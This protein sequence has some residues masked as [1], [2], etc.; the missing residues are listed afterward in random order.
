MSVHTD[1]PLPLF[2]TWERL[3]SGLIIVIIAGVVGLA[4]GELSLS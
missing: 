2:P 4:V 1:Q 3:L